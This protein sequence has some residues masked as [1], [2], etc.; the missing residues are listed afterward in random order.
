MTC[1][2]VQAL[3][4]ARRGLL[5]AGRV[6]TVSDTTLERIAA[7]AE[8][9]GALMRQVERDGADLREQARRRARAEA[10]AEA[11]ERARLAALADRIR[12][13]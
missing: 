1:F 13:P 9:L 3:H 7:E 2:E 11:E 10:R 5:P 12:F 4:A 8:C 6:L